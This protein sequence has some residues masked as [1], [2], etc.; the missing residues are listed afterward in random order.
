MGIHAVTFPIWGSQDV[1]DAA[2]MAQ[3]IN[4]AKTNP[5]TV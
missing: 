2:L 4:V 1:V 3:L 5:A